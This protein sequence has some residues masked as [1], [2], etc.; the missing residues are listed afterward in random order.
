[1]TR[2]SLLTLVR[3]LAVSILCTR[4]AA[5]VPLLPGETTILGGTTSAADPSLTGAVVYDAIVPFEIWGGTPPHTYLANFAML[6][7]QVIRSDL[8]GTLVFTYR[9]TETHES[10]NGW[11]DRLDTEM[12]H[13]WE[14]DVDF[15]WDDVGIVPPTGAARTAGGEQVSFL[16]ANPII[17]GADSRVMFI[18]TNARAY[19]PN[20]RTIIHEYFAGGTTVVPTVQPA[21]PG[22]ANL[23]GVVDGS[24]FGIW[25]ANKFGQGTWTEG[26]FNYDNL[27]DGSDFNIWN[28]HKYTSMNLAGNAAVPEPTGMA[29]LVLGLGLCGLR[30]LRD[31]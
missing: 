27:V 12:F 20:G 1:M 21:L 10:L 17:S 19:A 9:I 25:N 28:Q 6:H 8:D 7:N 4:L 5:A 23:D 2:F 11:I 16:F 31:I 22:D 30:R 24:D 18:K 13:G 29:L 14:T 26:D 15:R 3:L